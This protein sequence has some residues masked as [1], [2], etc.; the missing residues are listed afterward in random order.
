M[1]I[2]TGSGKPPNSL[3]GVSYAEP[4]IA[5]VLFALAGVRATHDTHGWGAKEQLAIRQCLLQQMDMSDKEIGGVYS[6]ELQI[7]IRYSVT[8]RNN[9]NCVDRIAPYTLMNGKHRSMTNMSDV[10]F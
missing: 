6:T 4:A 5:I 1:E 9:S 7:S 2:T 10:D 3:T 8:R